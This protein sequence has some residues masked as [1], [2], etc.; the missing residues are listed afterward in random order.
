MNFFAITNPKAIS[1]SG[2]AESVTDGLNSGL[3]LE[4]TFGD[5]GQSSTVKD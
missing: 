1:I 2:A 3:D 4:A 5:I